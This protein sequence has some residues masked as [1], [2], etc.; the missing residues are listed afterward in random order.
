MASEIVEINRISKKDVANYVSYNHS[1]NESYGQQ[2]IYNN[3]NFK[4]F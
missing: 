3:G 2:L 4:I 1:L